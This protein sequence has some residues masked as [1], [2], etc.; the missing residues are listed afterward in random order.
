MGVRRYNGCDVGEFLRHK[1][2]V[3]QKSN[4]WTNGATRVVARDT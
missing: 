4:A 2:P 3:S 1:R